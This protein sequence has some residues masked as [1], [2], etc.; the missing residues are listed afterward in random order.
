MHKLEELCSSL[1]LGRV[2]VLVALHDVD[3]DGELALMRSQ[4]FVAFS[5][6]RVTLRPKVP[7]GRGILDEEREIVP[8]ECR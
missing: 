5:N 3:V 4:W 6:F 7:D 1:L 2:D 8:A